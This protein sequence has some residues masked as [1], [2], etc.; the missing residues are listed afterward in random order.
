MPT[1]LYTKFLFTLFIAMLLSHVTY[2]QS[3][4]NGTNQYPTS[5]V[6]APTTVGAT[7]TISTLQYAGEYAVLTGLVAGQTYSITSDLSGTPDYITIRDVATNNVLT[8]GVSTLTYIASTSND[9]E[10]HFTLNDGACGTDNSFHTTTITLVSL[11]ASCTAPAA[12]AVFNCA[13]NSIDVNVT[14]IGSPSAGSPAFS[15]SVD[16]SGLTAQTITATGN[17]TFGPLTTDQSY[18]LTF[19]NGVDIACDQA[20]SFLYPDCATLG[21]GCVEAVTSGDLE[22]A[23]NWTEL[24]TYDD[25]FSGTTNT[26]TPVIDNTLPL[27]ANQ[28]A[29]LGGYGGSGLGEFLGLGGAPYITE[30]SQTVTLTAGNTVNLSFWGLLGVCDSPADVFTMSVD[31]NVQLTINGGD[32]FCGDVKWHKY[33]IDISAFAD[34]GTHTIAFRLV[35]QGN[36]D[37]QTNFFIDEISIEDCPSIICNAPVASAAPTYDCFTN[38]L[39]INLSNAGIPA[40]PTNNP[41]VLTLSGGASATPQ[42]VSGTG[43]YTFTGLTANNTYTVTADDGAGCVVNLGSVV[44]NCACLSPVGTATYDCGTD[45]IQLNIS[46]TGVPTGSFNASIDGGTPVNINSVGSYPPSSFGSFTPDQTYNLVFDNGAGCTSSI[47]Y[48]YGG[49][50]NPGPGCTNNLLNGDFESGGGNWPT[51]TAVDALNINVYESSTDPHIK[52]QFSL[53]A[54]TQSAVLGRYGGT[55]AGTGGAPY[56]S[57]VGKSVGTTNGNTM[58]LYFWV[59]W[60]ACDSPSDVLDVIIDGTVVSTF[61]GGAFCNDDKW[62]ELSVNMDAY[63]DGTNANI[64]FSVTE[65]EANGGPTRVFIDDV[66]VDNCTPI[67][68]PAAFNGI[69]GSPADQTDYE[70][71]GNI[72][73]IQTIAAGTTI[74]YDAGTDITLGIAGSAGFEVQLGATFCAFIDGCN[75]MGGV[76]NPITGGN[77]NN[78]QVDESEKA[79]IIYSTKESSHQIQSQRTG[80][81]FQPDYPAPSP[82]NMNKNVPIANKKYIPKKKSTS[83]RK[84]IKKK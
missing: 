9:I 24:S 21:A 78:L 19:S 20:I 44:A 83:K 26:G 60:D 6:T 51:N 80:V 70:T 13:T 53:G 8:E 52:P 67:S 12:T 65:N 68:C 58:T 7:T 15:V 76:I 5:S 10:A 64:V 36:N 41:Y 71:D 17:Y 74:D 11:T 66:Q 34:G 2:G 62:H 32:A 28:S 72:L 3:C 57:T 40:D 31:N 84:K 73:S 63:A 56:V 14:N 38:Q 29:W 43:N 30:I 33:D 4:D 81:L 35:E 55:G 59:Y 75:G 79:A 22:N 49:C 1:N 23:A 37:S 47:D 25:W 16:G 48:I 42:T 82:K 50:R 69:A 77:T 27:E 54:G 61:T 46:N 45:L 39:T 18:N